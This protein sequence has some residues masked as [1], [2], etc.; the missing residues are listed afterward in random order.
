MA[1]TWLFGPTVGHGY[2]GPA[3]HSWATIQVDPGRMGLPPLDL[4][5][6]VGYS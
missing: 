1:M 6:L 4:V 5:P 2:D 3:S